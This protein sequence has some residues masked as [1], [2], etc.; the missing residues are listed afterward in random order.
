MDWKDLSAISHYQTAVSI[1]HALEAGHMEEA[2]NGIM[3]LI[4]A[5]S[6][7]EKRA[8]R[9]QLIRLM[10]HVIKWKSQPK[11][12]S[13]SWRASIYN[14]RREIKNI[15]EETPSLTNQVIST[16][17]DDCLKAA[18]LEAEGEMNETPTVSELGWEEVFET[19][20]SLF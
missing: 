6:R 19:E 18:L 7:S 9:S 8:L 2:K 4:D 5:L 10:L 12:R 1:Q 3:E 17:W 20:Y 16:L 15:Q 14:S 11:Q 13:R